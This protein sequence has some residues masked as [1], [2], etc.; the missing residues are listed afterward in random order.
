M[1]KLFRRF[2][3]RLRL[4]VQ[5]LFAAVTNGYLLGFVKG[6]IYT[7]PSKALCLPGLNCYSCPGALGS[8]PIGSLQAVLGSRN[9]RFSFYVIGF[10]MLAGSLFGRFICGWLCPFG[11]IQDLLYKIPFLGK[12]KNLPGHRILVWMTYVILGVF[13]IFLP[14]AATAL[15]ITTRSSVPVQTPFSSPPCPV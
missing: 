13:V 3:R 9:Y 12:R 15:S 4:W 8:C 14:L 10:L 7:G 11:L 5:I 2:S 1:V 6:K